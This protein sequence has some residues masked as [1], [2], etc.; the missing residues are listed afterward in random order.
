MQYALLAYS[1][2]EDTDRVA[3]PIPRGLAAQLDRLWGFRIRPSALTWA[4]MRPA[5][6]R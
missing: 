6:T 4:F 5:R 3:R 2:P 1:P